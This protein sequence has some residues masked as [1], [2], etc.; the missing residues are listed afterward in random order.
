[1]ILY[2]NIFLN[3][4]QPFLATSTIQSPM[5]HYGQLSNWDN[6]AAKFHFRTALYIPA[7]GLCAKMCADDG[8]CMQFMYDSGTCLLSGSMI[9][10]GDRKGVEAGWMLDRIAGLVERTGPCESADLL[11]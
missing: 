7:F 6:Q 5:Q 9:A 2:R 1:M 8:G 10:G 4:T 11:P 3:I